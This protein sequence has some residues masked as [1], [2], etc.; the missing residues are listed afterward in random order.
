MNIHELIIR[1]CARCDR[2]DLIKIRKK[3]IIETKNDIVNF[4]VLSMIWSFNGFSAFESI[5]YLKDKFSPFYDLLSIVWLKRR[6]EKI[7][8][9]D[10]GSWERMYVCKEGAHLLLSRGHSEAEAWKGHELASFGWTIGGRRSSADATKYL[11][12]N[13]WLLHPFIRA[14]WHWFRD[15]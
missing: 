6:R 2:S 7:G 9:R 13:C 8:N 15:K 11:T 10:T 1:F 5:S 14:T 12:H 3:K 4:S